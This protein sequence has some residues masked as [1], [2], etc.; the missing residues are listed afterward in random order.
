MMDRRTDDLLADLVIAW[1]D[2]FR[3]GQDTPAAELACEHPELI[4]PLAR[5][6]DVLKRARWLDQPHDPADDAMVDGDDAGPA[7]PRTLA[8]RYRLDRRVAVGGFS[9]VWRAFDEEL[10]RVVAVK[11]P[12]SS[13][14]AMSAA[15]LAEA[16]RVARLRH[17]AIA[18]VHDVGIDDD[19]C[20]IVSEFLAGGSLADRLASAPLAPG[21][22]VRWI[23]Q[24]AAALE[25]AH[26]H[27]VIHRDVKPA[28]ILINHHG[29]AVLTDFGIAQSAAKT[30]AFAPSIGTLRYMAPEQL[31][32]GEVGPQADIY[33]LGV[34]LHEV[35]T[36]R[37]PYSSDEPQVIYGALRGDRPVAVAAE[38]PPRYVS[39]CSRALCRVPSG[40]QASAAAFAAEL[41]R[42]VAG[43]AATGPRSAAKLASG[44]LGGGML[45]A[46]V[47]ALA[48]MAWRLL[49]DDGSVQRPSMPAATPVGSPPQVSL[50][51]AS[52]EDALPYAVFMENLRVYREWQT[53]PVTY[54][55]P[56]RN[57]IAGSV[58]FRFDVTAPITAA[59][60][61]AASFCTDFTREPGGQG[62]GASA[63]AVSRDGRNWHSLHDNI[64]AK[65]WSGDWRVDGP[66]PGLVLGGTSILIRVQLLTDSCPNAGYTV[67]QFGRAPHPP[68]D[69]ALRLILECAESTA[70]RAQGQ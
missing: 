43:D 3:M 53:P 17:P 12:K 61:T 46:A 41:Q 8:G 30:G 70:G 32:G 27:G 4:T 66:L 7:E 37:S 31:D 42:A 15:F 35:L 1:E 33:S 20:F 69:G 50:P 16:R 10:E 54:L 11:I 56:M 45:A 24:I 6:I 14:I 21:Q 34:L 9:E 47:A 18:A 38:L 49:P 2:R 57:G 52:I 36:G 5:R 67:A 39:L 58:V 40:R 60:L 19:E 23:G 55:G 29:D 59:R 64:A 44:K 63:L 28:N 62:R 25:F 13:R 26:V 48:L 22:A 51:F 65:R 68:G